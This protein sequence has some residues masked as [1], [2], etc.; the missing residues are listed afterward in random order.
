MNSSCPHLEAGRGSFYRT[1]GARS[2]HAEVLGDLEEVLLLLLWLC[3][4]LGVEIKERLWINRGQSPRFWFQP[5]APPLRVD[6]KITA[7]RTDLWL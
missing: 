5:P 4:L 1:E 6:G 2:L 3:G 7:I